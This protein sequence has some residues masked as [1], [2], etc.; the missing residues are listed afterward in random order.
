MRIDGNFLI[1]PAV[2]ETASL[3]ELADGPFFWMSPSALELSDEFAET[4]PDQIE[5]GLMI[6][7]P[8]PLKL[9]AENA[10]SFL[11]RSSA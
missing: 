6:R 9:R 4:F 11:L 10:S 5:P 2:D 8:V 3:F 1:G 7:Y